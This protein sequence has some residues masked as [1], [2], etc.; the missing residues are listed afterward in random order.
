MIAFALLTYTNPHILVLD[1]PSNHL[2]LETLD[3]FSEAIKQFKGGVIFVSHDQYFLSQ[4]CKEMYYVKDTRVVKF[5]GTL[6]EYK[7]T[8]LAELQSRKAASK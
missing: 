1:E 5:R 4:C 2:D 6:D 8:I 7:A 3:A